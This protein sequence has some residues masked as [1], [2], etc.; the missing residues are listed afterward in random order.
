MVS[1]DAPQPWK[2]APA[3]WVFTSQWCG[4]KELRSTSFTVVPA[5]LLMWTKPIMG[6]PR[7]YHSAQMTRIR[8][9]VR[10]R[11]ARKREETMAKK[12]DWYYYR[13]G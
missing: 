13:K 7:G 10:A 1:R 9:L 8:G 12:A 4:P 3:C 11:L 2:D 5:V 6:A